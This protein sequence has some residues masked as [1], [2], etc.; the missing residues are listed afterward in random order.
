[1]F[2]TAHPRVGTPQGESAHRDTT[3]TK[4]RRIGAVA[5]T[6]ALGGAFALAAPLSASAATVPTS[7]AEARFLSGTLLGI[8]LDQIV[9]VKG[10][11]ATNDGTQSTQTQKDPLD[12]EVLQAINVSSNPAPQLDLGGVLQVGPVGQYATASVDG[13][14][15]AATGA[16]VDD[17]VLGVG[18][19][20]ATPPA[21]AT[22]DLQGLL[23]DEFA[24]TL[25]DLKLEIGAIAARAEADLDTA[26]GDYQIADA[27][28]SFSSPA[29]ANLTPKVDDALQEVVDALNGLVGPGGQLV[30]EVNGLLVNLDPVLNL[31]GGSGNVTAT[32][33]TGD[34][35]QAVE[36]IL[37]D[38]YGNGAVSFDLE[39]GTVNVDLE[40]LLGGDLNDLAPGTELL[41]D[42]V[43]NQILEGITDTVATI[44]DQVVE[45]VEQALNDANVDISADLS[46]NVAQ[47][48][49]V[50]EICGLV[51]R[52][53]TTPVLRNLTGAE[54]LLLQLT[55]GLGLGDLG[56]L[57]D[58]GLVGSLTDG[59]L[60]EVGDIVV[61]D[62]TLQMITGFVNQTVQDNVCN[63]TSTAV[64]PLTTS[65]SLDIQATIDE[66]LNGVAARAVADV[67]I[68]GIP[69]DLDLDLALGDLGG[70]L[71]D[72]LFD[73]DGAV[74]G[75][76]DSLQTNLVEPATE[77]LLGDGIGNIGDAL[78]DIVSVQANVQELTS[79]GDG[80]EFTQTALRVEV[81]GGD[82]TTL[83]LAQAT[84][85]PNVTSIVDPECTDPNGCDVGGETETP[86]GGGG[87]GGALAY[88]GIGIATLIAVILALLAAG[89][90]LVRESYRRNHPVVNT[91]E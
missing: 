35:S 31:L 70:A 47:A 36:S 20:T 74:Q 62:G 83:N 48:P 77:V 75:L 79:T 43:V 57:L 34:L 4:A 50:Q 22:L 39:A 68:L 29:I 52:V 87:G 49:L 15:A 80:G 42:D 51:D 7:S 66:L 56:G 81:L 82:L 10:A 32:I 12:A 24:S 69:A 45:K 40:Q 11:S 53:L 76:I 13:R 25:L 90:Y 21:N 64:A 18:G 55:S 2:T 1:M 5:T 37:Q 9:E 86:P 78:R 16:V 71:T 28:L 88:T 63:T 58:S 73:G 54:S 65:V 89:A 23:G 14:S 61:V 41:T 3:V 46:V 85:G 59:L 60:D 38:E 30:D 44:A 17:G 91:I 67:E 6:I 8:D 84:V 26:S 33:N 19:D 27:V 72:T